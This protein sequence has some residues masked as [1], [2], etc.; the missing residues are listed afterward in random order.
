MDI[1]TLIS[2]IRLEDLI[3][4][5]QFSPSWFFNVVN[6]ISTQIPADNFVETTS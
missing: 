6:V 1:Y 2:V 5:Y 3:L 4:E